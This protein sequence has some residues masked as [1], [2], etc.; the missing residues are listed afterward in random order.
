MKDLGNSLVERAK[1]VATEAHKNRYRKDK[2]TPYITHPE[3]VFNLLKSIGMSDQDILSAAWLHDVLEDTQ[4]TVEYIEKEFNSKIVKIVKQL[5]RDIDR[6][7]YKKRI[8]NANYAVQIIKLADTVDNCSNLSATY[9]P[10]KT[11]RRKIED[12]KS[13]YLDLAQKICPEFYSMLLELLNP[14]LKY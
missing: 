9:L 13:L 1:K 12:C 5:T 8:Q 2:V 4:I 14:W 10:E 11:V 6:E 7:G 3:N